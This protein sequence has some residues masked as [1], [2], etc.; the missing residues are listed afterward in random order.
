MS[1]EELKQKDQKFIANTYS[2]FPTDLCRGEGA[3]LWSESGKKYVDFGSGIAVN[4]FG[5]NDEEWKSA[6][7]AQLNKVQHASNLYYTRPQ[8][9]LAEMLCSRT[10]AKKVFFSN[11]GAEA[12]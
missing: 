11:S 12:N 5:V 6:V 10:G 4:S 7:I 8:A 2:R 3:T 1:F 9:E